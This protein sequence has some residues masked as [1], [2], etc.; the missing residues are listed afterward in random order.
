MTLGVFLKVWLETWLIDNEFEC[1]E[2]DG[3]EVIVSEVAVKLM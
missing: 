2:R 3:E 1:P